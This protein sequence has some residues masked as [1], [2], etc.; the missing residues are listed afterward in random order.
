V[1]AYRG[2][3]AGNS[4]DRWPGKTIVVDPSPM[5]RYFVEREFESPLR[6]GYWLPLS[7]RASQHNA[8]RASV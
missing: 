2:S 5:D 7:E 6:A 4:N 8:L 1:K 3:G